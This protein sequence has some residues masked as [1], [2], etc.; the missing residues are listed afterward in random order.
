MSRCVKV[1]YRTEVDAKI[2]MAN[3]G[4]KDNPAR[5]KTE[6]RAYRCPKC[7]GWQLTSKRRGGAR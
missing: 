4:A 6:R 3:I 1:R 2:A 7:A 5:A